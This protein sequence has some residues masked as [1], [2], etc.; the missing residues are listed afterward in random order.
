MKFDYTF[1]NQAYKYDGD[2]GY[3]IKKCR[4]EINLYN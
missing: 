3:Q 1:G 4:S 2:V